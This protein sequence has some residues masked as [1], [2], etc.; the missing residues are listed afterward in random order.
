VFKPTL[1]TRSYAWPAVR[2]L[3]TLSLSPHLARYVK[4]LIIGVEDPLELYYEDL[5][6]TRADNALHQI[7][8]QLDNVEELVLEGN[9][10]GSCVNFRRKLGH[11]LRAGILERCSSERLV[12][13]Y[14]VHLKNVPLCL[15]SLAPRLESLALQSVSFAPELD[16][17]AIAGGPLSSHNNIKERRPPARLKAVYVRSTT[18]KQ[19]RTL[20]PWLEHVHLDLTHIKTLELHIDFK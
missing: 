18:S 11:D 4:A 10:L 1:F 2:F 13:I 9:T 15:L 5:S 3:Q 12:V 14:L 7:L 17:H 16:H 20:Y 19:W 8:P 6:W